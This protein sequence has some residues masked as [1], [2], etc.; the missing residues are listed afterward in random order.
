[1]S[2][3]GIVWT[4]AILLMLLLSVFSIHGVKVIYATHSITASPAGGTYHLPQSVTL[5]STEPATIYYTTDGSEPTNSSSA[6][7]GPISI[8]TNTTLMFMAVASSDNHTASGVETYVIYPT[9][10][11]TVPSDRETRVNVFSDINATFSEPMDSSTINTSTFL[12]V[13][14]FGNQAAGTVEYDNNSKTAIFKPFPDA[15]LSSGERYNVTLTSD[16]KDSSGNTL[17]SNYSWS[18]TTGGEI[19][20][21]LTDIQTGEGIAGSAFTITPNPFTLTD[22]LVVED[23][24][25][26]DSDLQMFGDRTDGVI[27]LVNTAFSSF[28]LE[29]T[30]VPPQ[31]TK[32]YDTFI[33]T[34]HETSHISVLEV[35]NLNSSI[36][37]ND[38]SRTITVPAP[39]L[40]SDQF[41]LYKNNAVSGIF[42]G[43]QSDAL[44]DSQPIS[45]VEP[46]NIPSAQIVTASTSDQLGVFP[47]HSVIFNITASPA[48]TGGQIFS[49][50]L[51]P[52]Y[53]GPSAG[54][55][56]GIIYSPP[57]FVIPYQGS[58]N[59]FIT[60]PVIANIHP[61]MTLFMQQASFVASK[62]AKV[63]R[64]NMTFAQEGSN[65]GFTFGISDTR[66]PGTPEP[67]LDSSALFLDVGFVGNVDFSNPSAF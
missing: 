55:S 51:I 56:N 29:Q 45:S 7:T 53:P 27:D 41:E 37:I 6:Y 52:K 16:I 23:N 40:T 28:T 42:S 24:G 17:P 8:V 58:M 44:D 15:P 34:V 20:I 18:F 31:Y 36:S 59:N 39:Y 5:E 35:A 33:V 10:Q 2:S 13:D 12:I 46:F 1:V 67:P 47:V 65:V 66:P 9:V 48:T 57:A 43:V 19:R 61:N 22:S 62:V 25:P 49:S 32:L 38:L 30:T 26:Y 14:K 3:R 21:F 4:A 11:S 50:F 64:V 63:E 60:T 54:I